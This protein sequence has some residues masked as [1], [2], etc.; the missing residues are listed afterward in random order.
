MDQVSLLQAEFL[1]WHPHFDAIK[2][3]WDAY[4]VMHMLVLR[5][6]LLMVVPLA[7]QSL[8]IAAALQLGDRIWL[9]VA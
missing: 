3:G 4:V 2:V 8:L 9:R 5:V 1:I 6:P 7:L